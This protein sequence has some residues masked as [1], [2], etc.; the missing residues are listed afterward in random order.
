M[1]SANQFDGSANTN[2]ICGLRLPYSTITNQLHG[3]VK[4]VNLGKQTLRLH[5][6]LICVIKVENC[7]SDLLPNLKSYSASLRPPRHCV[8]SVT[9]SS[10]IARISSPYRTVHDHVSQ[11][12]FVMRNDETRKFR[13]S[14]RALLSHHLD[15]V[16]KLPK[17]LSV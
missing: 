2:R 1:P 4:I 14:L 7:S 17:H 15:V 6:L 10:M 11:S 16:E 5:C 12:Y 8:R 9:V 13:E 3:H